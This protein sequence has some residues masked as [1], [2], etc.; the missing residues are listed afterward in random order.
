MW[1]IAL[2]LVLSSFC[3]CQQQTPDAFGQPIC[4]HH[5]DSGD[6]PTQHPKGTDGGGLCCQCC[7]ASL[8]VTATGP[9]LDLPVVVA[10][11]R[12]ALVAVHVLLPRPS[13]HPASP[14]RGPP[15][16]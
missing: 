13:R 11:T 6:G 14:P 10:W 1:A 3:N 5:S 2:N 15:F 8:A 16:A 9:K 7:C 12:P 4:A